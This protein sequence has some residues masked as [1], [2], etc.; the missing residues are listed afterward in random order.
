MNQEDFRDVVQHS[1]LASGHA[2][3]LP[4]VLSVSKSQAGRF[5]KNETIILKKDKTV[6]ASMQ[7][8]DIYTWDFENL[9]H[10]CVWN[11]R[12]KASRRS[13]IENFRRILRRR[14]H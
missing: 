8:E 11:H 14:H 6:I 1:R 4:I 3:T 7:V 10:K 13:A 2:W 9:C 12:C 5:A